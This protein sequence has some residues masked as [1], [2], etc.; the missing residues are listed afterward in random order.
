M[1]LIW[2]LVRGVQWQ[3]DLVEECLW[4]PR[5]HSRLMSTAW[6]YSSFTLSVVVLPSVYSPSLSFSY[7]LSLTS[8]HDLIIIWTASWSTTR[9]ILAQLGEK[10][11]K[12]WNANTKNTKK[13]KATLCPFLSMLTK[14][15]NSAKQYLWVICS[16]TIEHKYIIG[17]KV[18]FDSKIWNIFNVKVTTERIWAFTVWTIWIVSEVSNVIYIQI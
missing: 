8:E 7:S 4:L 14:H 6:D 15:L 3:F 16:Y 9:L 12:L 17:V 18:L 10:W 5:P 2:S 1:S 13:R 11:K